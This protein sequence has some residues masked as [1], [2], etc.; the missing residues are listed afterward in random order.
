MSHKK[1]AKLLKTK[2]LILFIK[3]PAKIVT[4]CLA[5]QH[6]EKHPYEHKHNK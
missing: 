1:E 5:L 6:L 3:F 4:I 2:L